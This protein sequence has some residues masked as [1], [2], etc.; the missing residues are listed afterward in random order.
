MH[1]TR[2]SLAPRLRLYGDAMRIVLKI[3]DEEAFQWT[4]LLATCDEEE[5][6]KVFLLLWR[7]WHLRNHVVHSTGKVT[8]AASV[9]FL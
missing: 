7:A 9:T 8:I 3:P 2:R 1:T 5:R 6:A 4:L